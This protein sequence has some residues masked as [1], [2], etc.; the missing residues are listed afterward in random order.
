M[1]NRTRLSGTLTLMLAVCLTLGGSS[2]AGAQAPAAQPGNPQVVAPS[3]GKP[4]DQ[5]GQ[6]EDKS[7]RKQQ[8][9]TDRSQRLDEQ[10]QWR[11]KRAAERS[12]HRLEEQSENQQYRKQRREERDQHQEQ[13]KGVGAAQPSGLADPAPQ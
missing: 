3:Q 11:H 6:K 13:K 7:E 5:S 4:A 1:T 9:K 10:E 12:Q 8:R 2:T